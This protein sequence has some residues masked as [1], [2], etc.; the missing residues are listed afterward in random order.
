VRTHWISAKNGA[1]DG[2]F[3]GSSA[4][5]GT[6]GWASEETSCSA[7]ISC[8]TCTDQSGLS[9]ARG[10]PIVANCPLF[11]GGGR[12]EPPGVAIESWKQFREYIESFLDAS[13]PTAPAYLFPDIQ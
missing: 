3:D 8:A 7:I 6:C 12:D 2:Q 11:L 1:I 9:G 13:G 4:S 10:I 5:G